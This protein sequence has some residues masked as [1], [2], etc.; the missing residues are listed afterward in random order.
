M[1]LPLAYHW[2][3]LFVRKTTTVLTVCVVAAVVATFAWMFSFTVALRDTLSVAGDPLKLIVIRG[4]STSEAQSA[5]AIPDFNKLSQLTQIAVDSTS[6]R[7]L[8]SPETLSQVS[9][10]RKSD[11]G[12]TVANV[13]VRGVLDIARQV[14]TRV[15]ISKG[16]WFDSGA[17]EIVVGEAAA[18]QFAGLDIGDS[19]ELGFGGDRKYAIVGHFIA[20]GGPLESEIWGYLPSLLN[21]YNRSMYSSAA[22]RLQPDS[23]PRA[24]I[25]EIEGPAIQLGA[26]TEATYWARQ[27]KRISGYLVVAY[28]LVSVMFLAAIFAVAITMFSAVAG[29]TREVGMLR[30]LGFSRTAI[31]GGFMLEAVMLCIIGAIVGCAACAGWL[32]VFGGA[33]DMYGTSTFTSLAFDIHLTPVTIMGSLG[34]VAFVGLIGALAPAWRA[35]RAKVINVL[36]EG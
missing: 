20:A 36:R 35:S 34:C 22:L 27:S 30:T 23:D 4:G 17:R 14:H 26:M 21:A 10:G 16:R 32:S 11:G 31:M 9:L 33:K 13:A 24:V 25:A 7:P 12:R 15:K 19:L 5:I 3:N 18:R 8:V 2:R 29:R 28:A 6:G 1:A